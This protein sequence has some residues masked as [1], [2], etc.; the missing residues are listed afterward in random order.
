LFTASGLNAATAS[1][2]QDLTN[3]KIKELK[4]SGVILVIY[5]KVKE[6]KF[7]DEPLVISF[8]DFFNIVYPKAQEKWK[9]KNII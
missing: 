4:N 5:K 8:E 7:K 2:H 3:N 1:D 9:I 6:D